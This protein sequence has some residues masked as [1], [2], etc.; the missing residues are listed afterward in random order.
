[1]SEKP[2]G[3]WGRGPF[4]RDHKIREICD[5]TSKP[6]DAE[7]M[8]GLHLEWWRGVPHQHACGG[9]DLNYR[10]LATPEETPQSW[11]K[12]P[13][14]ANNPELVYGCAWM[15]NDHRRRG[16][17]WCHRAELCYQET[18]SIK[19]KAAK[20]GLTHIGPDLLSS[21]NVEALILD[22]DKEYVWLYKPHDVYLLSWEHYE[23]PWWYVGETGQVFKDRFIQHL[24]KSSNIGVRQLI[25]AG[26]VPNHKIAMAAVP[27]KRDA[28]MLGTYIMKASVYGPEGTCLTIPRNP[29]PIPELNL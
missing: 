12:A 18:P 7:S 22:E 16:E 9:V 14:Q 23:L 25:D 21:G 17:P 11:A 5:C 10:L 24:R 13:E 29:H 1:M 6:N 26:F 28:R 19:K 2:K 8:I 27:G 15:R 3:G 20:Q 4:Q